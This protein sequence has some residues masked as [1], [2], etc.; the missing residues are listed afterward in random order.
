[1]PSIAY[2]L[3][4]DCSNLRQA[5]SE[6]SKQDLTAFE[7]FPEP[8]LVTV[9]AATPTKQAFFVKHCSFLTTDQ[10]C[11]ALAVCLKRMMKVLASPD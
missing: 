9:T 2:R 7:S 3:R 11:F 4:R 10:Y 5:H 1:M 6:K 8:K